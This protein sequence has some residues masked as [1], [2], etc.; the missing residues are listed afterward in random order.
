MCS[1]IRHY[2]FQ[3]RQWFKIS[4]RRGKQRKDKAQ[5][6]LL[7]YYRRLRFLRTATSIFGIIITSIALGAYWVCNTSS[8]AFKRKGT[9]IYD[10]GGKT[11]QV[12]TANILTP[13]VMK[14][15]HYFVFVLRTKWGSHI[16]LYNNIFYGIIK[17]SRIK[18]LNIIVDVDWFF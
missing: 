5:S 16:L 10:D 15:L 4:N 17:C 9:R 13:T 8:K 2:N 11:V 14:L 12:F 1:R 7:L 6:S 3:T 18:I